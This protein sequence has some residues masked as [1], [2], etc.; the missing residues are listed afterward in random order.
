MTPVAAKAVFILMG[1]AWYIIRFPYARR[2]RR[3]A[4]V[5]SVRA[6]RERALLLVSFAGLGV[7]PV[8]YVATGFPKFAEYPF[9]PAQAWVGLFAAIAA[10]ALFLLTHRAL[11]RYWSISL[12]IRE[13]HR[14]V[15]HGIYRRIRHPMYAAFW[16]WAVAQA[17][18]LPN[19]VAGPAGLVG[20]GTLY[21]F[22]VGHEEQLMIAAFG[23]TY[24]E[25]MERTGRLFPRIINPFRTAD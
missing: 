24:R 8:S 17:L 11:G 22:R 21:F 18:L 19:E 9:R 6:W 4:V 14:L 13:N 1:V 23:D 7:V 20:F 2:S 15:T 10:L 3:T 16:L 25:Y 12:E 5:R